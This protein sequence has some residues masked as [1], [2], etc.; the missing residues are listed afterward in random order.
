MKNLCF[1]LRARG[2]HWKVSGRGEIIVVIID[3]S[4]CFVETGLERGWAEAGMLLE[5]F[6]GGWMG[7]T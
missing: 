6:L 2:R 7:G 3:V 1:I 4:D 5:G